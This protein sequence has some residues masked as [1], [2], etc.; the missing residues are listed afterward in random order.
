MLTFIFLLLIHNYNY[1]IIMSLRPIIYTTY[2]GYNVAALGND[3]WY[4]AAVRVPC[5]VPHAI[6]TINN[7]GYAN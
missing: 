1:G 3:Q 5:S 7:T 6:I 4:K 2:P